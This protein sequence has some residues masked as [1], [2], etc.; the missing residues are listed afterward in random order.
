MFQHF[1]YCIFFQIAVYKS[2]FH[3][4]WS[5]FQKKNE[6]SN[7]TDSH[8]FPN[9]SSPS[10]TQV[11]GIRGA[12][13]PYIMFLFLFLLFYSFLLFGIGLSALPPCIVCKPHP[14]TLS[15][16]G[17]MFLRTSVAITFFHRLHGLDRVQRPCAHYPKPEAA[18]TD[19]C[20]SMS[21]EGE[22]FLPRR[23]TL[24]AP[25]KDNGGLF[26][27]SSRIGSSSGQ[28]APN[29]TAIRLLA[30]EKLLVFKTF[31]LKAT[32]ILGLFVS[33]PLILQ[34]WNKL[35]FFCMITHLRHFKCL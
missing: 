28:E 33:A 1:K 31:G 26:H 4:I 2:K 35:R 34:P 23:P 8:L 25:L 9:N 10:I 7:I 3:E 30:A 14:L 16:N 27:P 15:D 21:L 24:S 5:I 12:R 19:G 32:Q 13:T 18:I 29:L 22:N 6:N 11:R 17:F 20:S